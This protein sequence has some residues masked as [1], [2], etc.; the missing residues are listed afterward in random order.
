MES[1]TS[2]FELIERFRQG[3]HDAFASL[4]EA[5]RRRLTV[6]IYF[7]LGADTR[8]FE[9]AEEILQETF[10]AAFQD[11]DRFEYRAPGSF[12]SWLSRIADHIII[13][14]VRFDG[15]QKRRAE[16]VLRFRS[17]TNPDGPDPADTKTPSRLFAQKEAI[18][19]LLDKLNAL[20]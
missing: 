8:S 9:N 14:V 19:R 2:T 13:D 15:R 20:P 6:L 4:F 1:P 3:D 16:Q 11:L 17:D 12:M 10:L 18:E 5:Y 7:K